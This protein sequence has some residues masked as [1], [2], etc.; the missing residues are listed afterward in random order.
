MARIKLVQRAAPVPHGAVHRIVQQQPV[1]LL[2]EVPLDELRKLRAHERELFAGMRKLIAVQRAQRRKLLLIAAEHLV[3]HRLFSVH[4]LVVRKREDKIFR[5]GVH[6]GKR[7]LVV[8]KLAEV[9]VGGEIVQRVVHKAHVP[10]EAEA[11]P[12]VVRRLRHVRIGGRLLR[13]RHAAGMGGEHGAVELLQ[14]RDRAEID[15]PAVAVRR[16]LAVPPGVV[17]IQHGRHRVHAD[18][19]DVI[20]LKKQHGGRDEEALHLRHRIVEDERAPLRMVGHALLLA[21]VKRRPI[22][23]GE[24][25]RVAR[26]VRRHPVDDD[27]DAGAVQRIDEEH[28]ILRRAVAGGGGEVPR[29][30]IAPRAVV[31]IL[32]H[33]QQLHM[34]VAHLA[35]VG[36]E[37]IGNLAVAADR[38]VR[39]AAP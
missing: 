1:Q 32:R 28:K 16:P 31:G 25:V 14:K 8:L 22:E 15:V 6:H 37:R 29:H 34:R 9:R 30:L 19:V 10:L 2:R 18:A 7:E 24:P 38:A 5:K 39:P 4:D 11:Q 3:Q 13:D 27:A 20:H 35:A 17:E 23:A 21:F 36:R 26:E 33:G 12:P